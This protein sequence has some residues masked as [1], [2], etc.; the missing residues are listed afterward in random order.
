[1]LQIKDLQV[2]YYKGKQRIPAVRGVS[3]DLNEGD[4]LGIV[5]ESGCGK[6]TVARAV[7]RLISP[8]EGTI[9]N[10]E[11]LYSQINI[12]SFSS[13]ELQ[14]LRGAEIS[15]VFQDPFNSLN[16]LF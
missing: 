6:S 8:Q 13:K 2:E 15:M 12:L 16:P 14:I 10:G 1:M 11:I 9:T 4:A 3:I 5:G 7:M